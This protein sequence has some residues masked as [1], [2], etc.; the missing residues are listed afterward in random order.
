[1][2]KAIRGLWHIWYYFWGHVWGRIFYDKKYLTGRWFEGKGHGIFAEGWKWVCQ[3]TTARIIF[4]QNTTA[5]YPIGAQMRVGAPQNIDF[6]P[7]DLNN[8]HT[9][10]C[11]F[12]AFEKITIGKGTYI[13][14]NVGIITANHDVNNLDDHIQAKPVTLGKACWIGMNSVVL[15]GVTL[16]DQTIVGAGSVVTKSFPQGKCI[17]AGNPARLIRNLDNK[18]LE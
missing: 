13:G 17:I 3:G 10:G 1:M 9:L 14:P 15:P 8:F 16:G 12:Q 2:K 6:D 7:D 4:R 18:M 11:Y 5:R